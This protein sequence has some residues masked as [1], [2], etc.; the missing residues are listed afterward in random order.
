MGLGE[1]LGRSLAAH[2]ARL[3]SFWFPSWSFRNV[4]FAPASALRKAKILP[5]SLLCCENSEGRA[6]DS[7]PNPGTLRPEDQG[8]IWKARER[9][10]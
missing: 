3:L 4:Q 7:K 6:L 1:S 2:P 8:S 10:G 5:L 9:M